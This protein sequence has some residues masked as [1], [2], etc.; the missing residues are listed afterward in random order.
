MED[1]G[2]VVTQTGDVRSK[3]VPRLALGMLKPNLFDAQ[4]LKAELLQSIAASCRD[5]AISAASF[6]VWCRNLQTTATSK[7]PIRHQ[8][9][10]SFTQQANL[11]V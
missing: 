5:E 10:N 9:R 4:E 6:H 11:A 8:S 1:G 3:W 7:P 2:I